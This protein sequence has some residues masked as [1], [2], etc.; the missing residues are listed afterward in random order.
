MASE[1]AA[2]SAAH[3]HRRRMGNL[4][5]APALVVIALMIVIPLLVAFAL[6]FTRYDLI[7]SPSWVGFDN[8]VELFSDPVFYKV[9]GNTFFFA[10]GQVLIGIVVA[11]FVAMLFNQALHGNALMRTTIYLPQAMSYVIVA[12]LWSF[13]YDPFNGPLN[14][15]IQA[16]GFERINF[17]TDTSLA[18]PSIMAMSLWRNMG[19]FMIILLAGLKAIPP[20]LLEAAQ[21]D[22]AGAFRRLIHV[23]IPQMKNPLL[24]VGVTWFMGGLQMFTQAYVMTSGGPDNATRTMVYE[25]YESAFTNLDIGR[26]SAVAMLLFMTVVL[27]GLPMKV[28]Q[29]VKEHKLTGP[30]KAETKEEVK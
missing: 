7:N 30:K 4:F 20:E 8:Y 6:S 27:F 24:F 23:T 25:M 2:L 22:G 16:L 5:A 26:A 17:L 9:V 29:T 14:A 15:F 1:T 11:F 13:L 12:L 19:Y 28:V 10:A 3:L 21:I 18:M